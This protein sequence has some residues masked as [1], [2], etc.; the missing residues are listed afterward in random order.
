MQPNSTTR[1]KDMKIITSIPL[2]LL[3]VLLGLIGPGRAKGQIFL[4]PVPG[5]ITGLPD[6]VNM[7][8]TVSF[9]YRM[10]NQGPLPFIGLQ[11]TNLMVNGNLIPLPIDSSLINLLGVGDTT[12]IMI[13]NYT[14]TTAR[15]Q[16][17]GNVMV[18]WPTGTGGGQQ[19]DSLK[20]DVYVNEPTFVDPRAGAPE[21]LAYPNPA[22]HQMHLRFG[23]AQNPAVKLTFLSPQGETVFMQA[24]E[25]AQ[26]AIIST[27]QL[28][29]GAYLLQIQ[30][31]DGTVRVIKVI[32]I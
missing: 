26:E 24:L 4:E 29:P 15:H 30:F 2:L 7:G 19:T 8:D 18:I 11:F 28:K 31:R 21:T 12:M 13:P 27:E 6:T 25:P 32:R 5:S 3:L 14:F 17:G 1:L 20:Q 23:D 10:V 16:G 9:A 22:H